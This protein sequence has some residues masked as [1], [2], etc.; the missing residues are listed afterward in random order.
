[1]QQ[2]QVS[3]KLAQ[4]N[5]AWEKLKQSVVRKQA[6]L[7]EALR[8]VSTSSFPLGKVELLNAVSIFG[9]SDIMI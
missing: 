9:F 3:T 1:M 5:R 7:E 8:E 4:V 6:K 2:A